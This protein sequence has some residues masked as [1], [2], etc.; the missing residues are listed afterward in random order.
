M[1]FELFHRVVSPPKFLRVR[2]QIV[3]GVVAHF[4]DKNRLLHLG[5]GEAT[6]PPCF[7]MAVAG[8]EVVLAVNVFTAAQFAHS[9]H[10]AANP[11]IKFRD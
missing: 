2:N 3:Q 4:A 11:F 6:F 10:V 1:R 9:G 5:F 8:D 7:A